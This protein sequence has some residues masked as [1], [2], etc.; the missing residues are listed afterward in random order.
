ME[1]DAPIGFVGSIW[2]WSVSFPSH[3]NRIRS[4]FTGTFCAKVFDSILNPPLSTSFL[5]KFRKSLSIFDLNR[6]GA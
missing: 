6:N 5:S 1:D 4:R 2:F 3:V